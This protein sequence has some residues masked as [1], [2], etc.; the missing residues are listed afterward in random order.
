MSLF[1]LTDELSFPPL[2]TATKEGLVAIGGDL[3]KE[4]LLLAYQKG[5]F[6]WYNEFEPIQWWSPNPRC[7]LFPDELKVSKS[8]RQILRKGIFEVTINHAFRDIILSCQQEPRKGQYGTWITEDIVRSYISFHEEGYAHSVEV[9]QNGEIV[10]GLYGIIIGK[11]F[12]GESMFSKVSNAS[13][14]AFVTLVQL[15]ESKG[16]YLID[17]QI[18]TPHL[19]S[20]GARTIPRS[21]FVNI[22]NNNQ[23]EPP[24]FRF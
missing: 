8:M 9:W 1:W 20:L 13:K 4:R 18:E 22:L 3:S 12:F 24:L 11:C 17:C 15:L 6:P 16:F 7:V 14:V 5:I 19:V 2:E 23:K 21:T 10:G